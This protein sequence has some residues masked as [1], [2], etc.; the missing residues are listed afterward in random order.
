MEVENLEINDVRQFKKGALELVLLCLIARGETYG[1][2]ILTA[3]HQQGGDIFGGARE[4][5]VYPVLYRLEKVGLLR[6]RMETV[7]GRSRKYYALTDAGRR[8]LG[9]LTVFW[10][11]FSRCVEGFLKEQEVQP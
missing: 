4:G 3:L 11:S 5:T 7:G 10:R 2:E 8:T 6:C 9:E 1:Y